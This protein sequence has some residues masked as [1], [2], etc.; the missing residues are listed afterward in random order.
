MSQET[1]AHA[2]GPESHNHGDSAGVP[3]EGRSFESNPHAG[4]DGSADPA[5]LAAILRFRAGEGS[6]AEVVD[7]FRGARV[8]VPLIAEKGDEGVAPNGLTVDK[9]Q[10]LSI[11][12]VAAPDGRRVQPV[13]SSVQ[14]MQAWIRPRDRF[15]SRRSAPRWRP[16]RKTPT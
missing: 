3:W 5:L 2:C 4:D 15:R 10:E 16:P 6:Q 7:A 9:T 8:L 11:V 14:A 13:F 12:T 1:D